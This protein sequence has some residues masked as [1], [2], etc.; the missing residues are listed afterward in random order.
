[1]S[2]FVRTLGSR[3]SLKYAPTFATSSQNRQITFRREI[4]VFSSDT[5]AHMAGAVRNTAL[6]ALYDWERLV[7]KWS[8]ENEPTG[9]SLRIRNLLSDIDRVT[10]LIE[11]DTCD[12]G[13]EQVWGDEIEMIGATMNRLG[14]VG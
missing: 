13:W 8:S 6:K 2:A 7:I 1:M 14:I 12:W 5:W 10:C 9:Q 3:T 11:S 4:M